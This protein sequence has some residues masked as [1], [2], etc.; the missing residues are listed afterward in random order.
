[1]RLARLIRWAMVASGTRYASAICRVVR[2]PTA[3]SV[4]ATAD[5][6]LSDGWAHRK[7][8]RRVSSASSAGPGG[9]SASTRASRA[10]RALSD[11]AASTNLRQATVTSQP[12]GSA[13]GSRGPGRQR[14]EQRLLH[15]VLG[16][17]EVGSATD[18]DP[19]H[20]GDEVPQQGLV[21]SVVGEVSVMNG[22]SSSHS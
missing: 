11:R 4:S 22:R 6:G 9:G 13:G 20:R 16:R 14:P 2:P 3:R 10:C 1:M 5:A 17:R 18:E 12:F 19:G 15:G 7:Y 21:H 8:S